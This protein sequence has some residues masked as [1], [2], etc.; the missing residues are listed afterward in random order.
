[1][2]LL[3]V[4]HSLPPEDR[5]MDNIGG[6]QRVAT[7][8]HD[9]LLS[10]GGAD[11]RTLVLRSPWSQRHWRT[12]VFMARAIR[13]IWK[14]AAAGEIDAVLFS[15]MVTASLAVPLRRHLSR[16]GVVSAAIANGLDAT[17]ATWPYPHFVRKVFDS[18]DLVL[19]ISN[20]TAAACRERGLTPEK[21][22]VVL[23]GI[24]LD[25]FSAPPLR[26]E[27]RERMLAKFVAPSVEPKLF[28]CSVGRLVPR[29]GVAWFIDEVM[30]TLPEDVCF[31]VAGEGAERGR[32]TG[33]IKR[34]GLEDRVR[35]LG[36]VTDSDVEL[37]YQGS[38]LFVMPNV[39]VPGDMEGFGLVLV[40]AGLCGLPAVAARL[41]GIAD[42]VT[43][44]E[45]GHLVEPGDA[46]GFR[47]AV[48]T[49]YSSP[50]DLRDASGRA[51]RHTAATFG[52]DRVTQRYLTILET[53][54]RL[55]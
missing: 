55:R 3:F 14:L 1:M 49:Y 36:A 9:S 10:H 35:L 7:D 8:L 37:L 32:I 24:R 38:D 33:A 19:P 25:R 51:K 5:P 41:E 4:S 47:D 11:V 23:L 16:H 15:S 18:L 6:M 27:A 42:V 46:A 45:N 52:W 31:L 44:G 29:K 50:A 30:P 48:M 40:E 34:H 20:A 26:S 2:R 17:T 22:S 43:E 13:R 21:C 53:R 54:A 28:L 39:R 12:P